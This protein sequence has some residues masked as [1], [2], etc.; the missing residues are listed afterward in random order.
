MKNKK[1]D[2]TLFELQQQYVTGNLEK[3]SYINKMYLRHKLLYEYEPLLGVGDTKTITLTSDDIILETVAGVKLLVD[4]SDSRSCPIEALN[5]GTFE[6]SDRSAIMKIAR[7]SNVIFDIGANVGWYSLLL[8]K[9]YPAAQVYA[10]E[11]L[12][13]TYSLLQKNMSLN[14]LTN[15]S[16]FNIAIFNNKKMIDLFWSETESGSTSIANLREYDDTKLIKV[17]AI[18]LDEFCLSNKIYPN[19]IKLDIEGSELFALQ[20]AKKVLQNKRPTIFCELLRKWAKKCGY[21]VNEVFE[22]LRNFDYKCYAVNNEKFM[23]VAQITEETAT[24]NFYFYPKEL[25]P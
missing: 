8:A 14:S 16:S 24:T 13:R 5:F 23:E 3:S 17:P 1:H 19:F 2:S 7:E 12:P 4:K 6:K 20:G 25:D 18:T 21:E 9:T 15:L 11:P 22:Y 10:F